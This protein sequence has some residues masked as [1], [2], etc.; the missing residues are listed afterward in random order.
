MKPITIQVHGQS[1]KTPW[2]ISQQILDL[3]RWPEFG[4]YSI[5]PG[6]RRAEFETKTPIII[7]SRIRVHNTDGST[8]VEEV[9]EWDDEHR[10]AL[11]FQDFSP[12]LSRL[13][14]HFL[15]TWEYRPLSAGTEI[16][17]SLAMYPKGL[18]GWLVL[19]PISRLMKKA[20]EHNARQLGGE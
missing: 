8:H 19:L 14:T 10:V 4:G 9:V 7:G 15:E 18:P 1:R 3:T 11:K 12:P 2:E 6:I 17:R 16:T 13:A 20:F 5:L